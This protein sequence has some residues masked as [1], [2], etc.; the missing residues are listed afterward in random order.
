MACQPSM[1]EGGALHIASLPF[2]VSWWG[3]ASTRELAL[4][5][6][7]TFVGDDSVRPAVSS[8]DCHTD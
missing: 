7:I 5:R 3:F 1:P 6:P 2:R 8:D 4:D